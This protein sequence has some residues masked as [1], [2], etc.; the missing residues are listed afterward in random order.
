MKLSIEEYF[1]VRAVLVDAFYAIGDNLGC[2]EKTIDHLIHKDEI[3][4]FLDG[5]ESNICNAAFKVVFDDFWPQDYLTRL[6]HKKEKFMQLWEK[7][8]QTD[9]K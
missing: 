8:K 2:S 9:I 3:E 1:I 6:G 7:L 4:F 5:N